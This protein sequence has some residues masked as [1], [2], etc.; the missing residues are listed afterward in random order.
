[1]QANKDAIKVGLG[2]YLSGWHQRLFSDTNAL[3]EYA[4]RTVDKAIMWAPGRMVDQVE[5]ML[6]AYRKN[7]TAQANQ[8]KPRLPIALVAMAK[9]FIAAPPEYGRGMGDE[10]DVIIPADGR[11]R[12]FRLSV[13]VGELRVQVAMIAAEDSTATSLA[14]Q[15]Q[16]YM[17]TVQNR[18]FFADIPVAGIAQRWPVQI[19]L[20]DIAAQSVATDVKNLT[21]LL[22]DFTLRATVPMLRAPG[23][24]EANDGRGGANATDPW[25]PNYDPH[26]FPV[27]VEAT[28][29]ILPPPTLDKDAAPLNYWTV[30]GRS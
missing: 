1:M 20:P 19:E 9:D 10:Q 11:E 29:A 21:I 7:D 26:G 2:R 8:P 6:E 28:G 22:T 14:T 16:R 17:S 27:V 5:E 23:A 24:G 18:V 25:A 15:L 12:L 3:R 30:G 13:I 4:S